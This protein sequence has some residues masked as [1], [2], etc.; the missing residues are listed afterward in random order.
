MANRHFCACQIFFRQGRNYAKF[1]LHWLIGCN[2]TVIRLLPEDNR[3]GSS[4]WKTTNRSS[5]LRIMKNQTKEQ[6]NGKHPASL[7]HVQTERS[8]VCELC[9]RGCGYTALLLSIRKMVL[10][11]YLE[12]ES[13]RERN[14]YM[15][16]MIMIWQPGLDEICICA[17][18]FIQL[19]THC[20]RLSHLQWS[21][22]HRWFSLLRDLSP[23]LDY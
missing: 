13:K 19:S 14:F 17:V 20:R 23:V 16:D 1:K 9:K 5:K 10:S 12:R 21:T 18:K 3:S 4:L 11:Q 22:D 15:G 8:I 6:M 2:I 7:L